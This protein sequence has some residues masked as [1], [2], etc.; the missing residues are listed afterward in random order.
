ML[1]FA[2]GVSDGGAGGDGDGVE[3]VGATNQPFQILL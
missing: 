2:R 3:G 1:V